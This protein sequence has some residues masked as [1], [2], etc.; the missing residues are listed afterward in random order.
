M[1]LYDKNTLYTYPMRAITIMILIYYN[2]LW[3]LFSSSSIYYMK[4]ED[5]NKKMGEKSY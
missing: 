3:Y 1:I 5:T 2:S 4:G